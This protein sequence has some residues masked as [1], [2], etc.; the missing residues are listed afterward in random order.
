MKEAILSGMDVDQTLA[1]VRATINV[2]KIPE[3]RLRQYFETTMD[4][5]VRSLL[6]GMHKANRELRS[7]SLCLSSRLRR[8]WSEEFELNLHVRLKRLVKSGVIRREKFLPG[9]PFYS[10][11]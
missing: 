4:H 9:R 10:G 5:E 1:H 6:H 11:F 8:N 2:N 3:E 7:I